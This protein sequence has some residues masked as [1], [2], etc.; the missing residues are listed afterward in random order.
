MSQCV[1]SHHRVCMGKAMLVPQGVSAMGWLA[2][3]LQSPAH[4]AMAAGAEKSSMDPT[5]SLRFLAWLLADLMFSSFWIPC[6][7]LSCYGSHPPAQPLSACREPAVDTGSNR[8]CEEPDKYCG[9]ADQG[10]EAWSSPSPCRCC[11]ALCH[12][13]PDSISFR[14]QTH[15][16]VHRHPRG[17]EQPWVCRATWYLQEN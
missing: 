3:P 13:H 14:Q 15:M 7:A 9:A 4:F 1:V 2:S 17:Q 16:E 11:P 12:P 10:A 6:S 5:C 8:K